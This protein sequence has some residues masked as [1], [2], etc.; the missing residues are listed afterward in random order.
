MMIHI[1]VEQPANEKRRLKYLAEENRFVPTEHISLAYA[2]GFRGVYG[3]VD[4]YGHPPDPHQDVFLLTSNEY[5]AGQLAA[6]KIVGCFIRN[7]GDNKIICIESVRSEE[8][9]NQLPPDE[10][11][12]IRNLYPRISEGEGWFGAERA[13]AMLNDW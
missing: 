5:Q 10:I 8:D 6:G 3:W 7:D 2:R 4:G 11:Q 9:L 12:M 13:L 1:V